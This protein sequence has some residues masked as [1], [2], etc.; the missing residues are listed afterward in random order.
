MAAP[1]NPTNSQLSVGFFVAAAEI[2]TICS[3]LSL[4]TSGDAAQTGVISGTTAATIVACLNAQRDL[5]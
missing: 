3:N 2:I 4:P 1:V 5:Y